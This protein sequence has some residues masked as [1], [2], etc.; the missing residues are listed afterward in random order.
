[1]TDR[2]TLYHHALCPFS[3]T[4]RLILRDKGLAY[5]VISELPWRPSETLL[6]HNPLGELPVLVEPTGHA[7]CTPQAIYE[8]L[9]EV[10]PTPN[11]LGETLLGRAEIRRLVSIF[12]TSFYRDVMRPLLDERVVKSLTSGA[13][14]D[15]RRIRVARDNL[16]KYLAY[17]NWLAERRSYLGGRHLSL[18]DLCLAA[19][20]SVLDYFGEISWE[21]Y[22]DLTI[23]YAKIKSRPSFNALLQDRIAGI[24]PSETYTNLDF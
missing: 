12:D 20:L 15:S 22:A 7:I 2:Y 6:K 11:L 10:R 4:V 16:K 19:H 1:M 14:P 18:A 24:I 17:V 13:D 3:R 8:Y 21:N 5:A 9:N 23:W